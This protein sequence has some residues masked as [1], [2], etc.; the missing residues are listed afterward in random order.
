MCVAL[1]GLEKVLV[2]FSFLNQGGE[3]IFPNPSHPSLYYILFPVCGPRLHSPGLLSSP[4]FIHSYNCPA[5]WQPRRPPKVC[6]AVSTSPPCVTDCCRRNAFRRVTDHR[7][8]AQQAK[9]EANGT[10]EAHATN[11][12]A[13]EQE[14][15]H[16]HDHDHD[17]EGQEQQVENVF[18]LTIQ[19]PHAPVRG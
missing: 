15:E 8:D 11:G 13:K 16:D 3:L 12:V 6:Q 17:Q 1:A 18:Q 5:A 7:I 14:Q 9:P 10:S 19:L 4:F 2:L